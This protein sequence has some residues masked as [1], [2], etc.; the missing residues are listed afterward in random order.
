MVVNG[1]FSPCHEWKAVRTF[2]LGECRMRSR[3]SCRVGTLCDWSIQNGL[4]GLVLRKGAIS[5]AILALNAEDSTATCMVG[6]EAEAEG[7]Y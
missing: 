3:Y 7:Q 5:S 1:P 6:T 4:R 2:G